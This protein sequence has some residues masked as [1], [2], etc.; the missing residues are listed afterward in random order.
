MFCDL[1]IVL[2]RVSSGVLNTLLHSPSPGTQ[3][4]AAS[5][6]TKLAIKAKAMSADSF[7]MGQ[8]MN[9]VLSVLKAAS[10]GGWKSAEVLDMEKESQ[11]KQQQK[12]LVSF[13]S[14]DT[15]SQ[16]LK[17]KNESPQKGNTNSTKLVASKQQSTESAS[18]AVVMTSV[19]RAIE[20]LA[21]IVGKTHVKEEIVHGSYRYPSIF[22]VLHFIVISLFAPYFVFFV[23]E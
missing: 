20:V 16:D 4:A 21:A 7:E 15:V 14:M 22:A 11:Q 17:N 8:I 5:T 13:S 12:Q 9:T 1:L 6:L 10:S 19:E 18:D 2:R 23:A 3:A